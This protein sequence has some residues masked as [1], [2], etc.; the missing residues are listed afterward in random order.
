MVSSG[1][2]MTL[3]N[4]PLPARRLS[5]S[6]MPWGCMKIRTPS[7]SALA[8]KGSNLGDGQLVAVDVPADGCAAQTQLLDA[9]FQLLSRQIGKLQRDRGE[10]HE[11]VR[12][13]GAQLGES[14]I[15]HFDELCGY[16]AIG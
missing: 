6:G 8:Q 15:L 16:V 5:S 13:R 10:G 7:S 1:L 2:P 14:L 11:P 12:M 3:P 4:L 9:V